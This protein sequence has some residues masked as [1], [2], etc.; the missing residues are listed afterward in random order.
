[1]RSHVLSGNSLP[2]TPDDDLLQRILPYT[3]LV[4]ACPF[5]KA[6]P[7][8]D[9]RTPNYSVALSS[10]AARRKA[11]AQLDNM[12]RYTR[13]AQLRAEQAAAR[14]ATEAQL[15]RPLTPE[16]QAT[17]AAISAAFQDAEDA[18]RVKE[19]A[20]YARC[21]EPWLHNEACHCREGQPYV[22]PAPKL[23]V[24]REVTDLAAVRARKAGVR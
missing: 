8:V 14:A 18:F 24:V 21:R 20:M 23:R 11:A 13:F 16:Q 2:E 15:A 1:M 4:V 10:H 12:E 17:R 7:A 3:Y 19:R 22:A 5:C 9:C 6:G